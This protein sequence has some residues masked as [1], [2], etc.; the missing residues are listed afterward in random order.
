MSYL[1]NI[2]SFTQANKKKIDALQQEYFLICET[3]R[4]DGH[5]HFPASI[6]EDDSETQD[7]TSLREQPA[8]D[9]II[10][11]LRELKELIKDVQKRQN[12]EELGHKLGTQE[13]DLA[14]SSHAANVT[15]I[16]AKAYIQLGRFSKSNESKTEQ[17]KIEFQNSPY[18]L[19][20]EK[21]MSKVDK[22]ESKKLTYWRQGF[23][24]KLAAG[25]VP[26]AT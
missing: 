3:P 5:G 26:P 11:E 18:G 12:N 7:L 10:Q 17:L 4:E 1:K 2:W 15:E 8:S 19:K 9:L 20:V 22:F 6:F 25:G 21:L 24:N 16:L 14:R 23:Q 13:F